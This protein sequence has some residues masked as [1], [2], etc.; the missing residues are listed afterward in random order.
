MELTVSKGRGF[1]PVENREKEKLELGTIAIDAIYTPVKNVNFEIENVRVEQFTNYDR[2]VLDITTDGTIT[3]NEAVK[4]AAS[5][6]VDHFNFFSVPKAKKEEVK[7]VEKKEV[8]EK[9]PAKKEE[10]KDEKPTKRKR[11]RPKKIVT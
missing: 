10:E 8:E 3:P 1:V 6:L 4:T 9:L 11:G 2:L 5:I 7:R